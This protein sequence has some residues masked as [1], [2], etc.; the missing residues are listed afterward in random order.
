MC[1]VMCVIMKKDVP[2]TVRDFY[3]EFVNKI[4][5]V[6]KEEEMRKSAD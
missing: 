2:A 5:R 4:N 3:I 1:V 6:N